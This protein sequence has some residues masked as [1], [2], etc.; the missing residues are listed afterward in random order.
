MKAE[1]IKLSSG[2]TV[3]SRQNTSNCRLSS[4]KCGMLRVCYTWHCGWPCNEQWTFSSLIWR[5]DH[6]YACRDT[7]YRSI[8]I[9][10]RNPDAAFKLCNW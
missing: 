9:I 2:C 7:A 3:T 6:T 10:C 5:P 4:E 1:G 8:I